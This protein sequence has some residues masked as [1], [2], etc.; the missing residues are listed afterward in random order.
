MTLNE[1]V[2]NNAVDYSYNRI[3]EDK[4]RE[5][6][7]FLKVGF[8]DQLK[9]YIL[10][11]GYLGYKYIELYGINSFQGINSDMVKKT[12]WLHGYFEKTKGLIAVEDQGD[13]DYYLVDSNDSVYRFVA[14]NNELIPQDTDLFNYILNRFLSAE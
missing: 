9:K 1:F 7:I 8:G 14:D 6:E 2:E 12:V 4:I 10:C 3:S 13:G 5:M 11:Y